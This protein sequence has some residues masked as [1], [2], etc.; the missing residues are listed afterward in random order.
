MTAILPRIE[1]L[2]ARVVRILGCNPG[3]MTLQGTNTYLVGTGKRRVLID[4]GEAGVAEYISSLQQALEQQ[5]ASIQEIVVTHWHHDHTGG[6][7]DICASLPGGWD[8]PVSKLPRVPH[9]EERLGE[10]DKKTYT[11]LRHGDL[12]HT[13]GATLK[14]LYTPGH[15]DDHMVLLLDQE[16]AL[17]SGDCI[18]GE[19][20]AVFE[21]LHDYMRSL[22]TLLDTNADHIYPGHGPVV[23]NAASKIREY[24]THRDLREQQILRVLQE[25]PT[26]THTAAEL[27]KIVYKVN[28]HTHTHRRRAGQDRLQGEHTHTHTHTHTAAEL[29]KIV[30]KDTPEHLHRA[31]EVNLT[32][33]LKKLQKEGHITAVECRWKSN[34]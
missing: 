19:G 15:T 8:L 31:A 2:S 3:P 9:Q 23:V 21:D 16:G 33:H 1:Q 10:E 6:V 20:T 29:V 34:L 7:P 27:V 11:Y 14:V 12:I 22:H 17:F 25:K 32:H 4:A 24:I 13:E 26:H 28:T 5:N 18:L 30:Y